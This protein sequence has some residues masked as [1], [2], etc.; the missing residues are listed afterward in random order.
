VRQD[1][2]RNAEIGV[3]T[4]LRINA[5]RGQQQLAGVNKVLI[6]GIARKAV[7]LVARLKAEEAA[8]AGD[9]LGG[10]I[11]PRTTADHRRHKGLD[12]LAV[13]DDRFTRLN[14]Q[15]DALCPQPATALALVNFG[16]DI[17]RGKQRVK[18]AGRGMKHKGV[19][20]TLVRAE[21]RLAAQV[22]IFF[23]DLRSL[24]E[25]RLL[26]MHRLG[27]ENPRIV[28]IQIEQQR[29]AVCHHRDK[30]LV[31]NPSRIKQDVV[32]QV[33]DLI[34]HLAGVV[35][36]AVIGAKLDHRQAERP[37]LFGLIRRDIA[38]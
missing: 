19:I 11:L 16:V 13:G 26:F 4:C 25:A 23:V 31:T 8:L 20:Q 21:T 32:A 18:G 3:F 37:R 15:L 2:G 17:E 33:A 34:D 24:R 1:S 27:D 6:L 38:D 36:R 7:P 12:H 28:F 5:R 22:V 10:V 9:K 30:L 35:D 29:R 14:A